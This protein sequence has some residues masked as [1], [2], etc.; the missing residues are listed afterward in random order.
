MIGRLG[1][2]G[3]G[4]ADGPEGPLFVPFALPGELVSV[5]AAPGSDRAGLIDV[6]EPSLPTVSRRSARISAF[7]VDVRSSISRRAPILPGSV[8]WSWL[9]CG[10][11]D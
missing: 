11:A 3:D 10:R 1:A 4:V 9:R 6:L 8:S 5:I 2:Q 7:V